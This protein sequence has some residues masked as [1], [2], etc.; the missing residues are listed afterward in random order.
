MRASVRVRFRLLWL[1]PE[2]SL[3]QV[4]FSTLKKTKGDS[5]EMIE[6]KDNNENWKNDLKN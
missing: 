3:Y 2:S 4:I 1:F 6:I 5:A